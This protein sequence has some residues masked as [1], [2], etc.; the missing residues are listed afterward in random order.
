LSR[1]EE[2]SLAQRQEIT[3]LHG[4]YIAMGGI[5]V[6]TRETPEIFVSNHSKV[7]FLTYEGLKEL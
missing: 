2:T 3:M 6:D 7:R 5:A 4:H 1:L